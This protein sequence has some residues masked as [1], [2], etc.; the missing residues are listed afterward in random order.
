M[1][2]L[3]CKHLSFKRFTSILNDQLLV[4]TVHVALLLNSS[5]TLVLGKRQRVRSITD[6]NTFFKVKTNICQNL[7]S[8]PVL[9]YEPTCVKI[10]VNLK[11]SCFHIVMV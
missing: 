2:R 6:Q 11:G 7:T 3:S 5:D 9:I 1:E 10:L 8:S 4:N